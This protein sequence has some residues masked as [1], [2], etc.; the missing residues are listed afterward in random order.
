MKIKSIKLPFT[1]KSVLL[2]CFFACMLVFAS[3]TK[4]DKQRIRE[5]KQNWKKEKGIKLD[6]FSNQSLDFSLLNQLSFGNPLSRSLP[7]KSGEDLNLAPKFI[8]DENF[9]LKDN[10]TV[11]SVKKIVDNSNY[12]PS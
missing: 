3:F 8:S 2:M 4:K 10:N 5:W 11:K 9:T 1:K 12:F 7:S 6:D